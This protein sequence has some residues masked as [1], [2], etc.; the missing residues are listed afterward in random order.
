MRSNLV[1][2]SLALIAGLAAACGPSAE[3]DPPAPA[4]SSTAA[5]SSTATAES[6]HNRS[7]V[8]FA[9]QMVPHHEQA[10]VAADLALERSASPEIQALAQRIKGA[11]QPELDQLLALLRLWGESVT[12]GGGASG[13]H[14]HSRLMSE[15]TFQQLQEATAAEF[16]ELWLRSMI[17]HHQGAVELAETQLR[18]GADSLA[19]LYAR[20]IVD[21]QRPEV[22]EMTALLE[23]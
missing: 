16:D 5:T 21:R 3:S 1:V 15:E 14:D 8:E 19:S 18:A 11:Q 7:D 9:Q 20:T 17:E 6:N 4:P 13:D 12:P 22:Q 23:R 10:V 2:P